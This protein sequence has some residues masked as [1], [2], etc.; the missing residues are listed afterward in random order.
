[1][2]SET[3]AGACPFDHTGVN[4]NGESPAPAFDEVVALM[5]RVQD[6]EPVFFWPAREAWVVAR[7]ESVVKVLMDDRMSAKGKH[8]A[9]DGYY[10]E[11]T[12]AVLSQTTFIPP[13]DVMGTQDAAEHDRLRLPFRAALRATAVKAYEQTISEICSQLIDELEPKRAAEWHAEFSEPLPMRVMLGILGLPVGDASQLAFWSKEMVRLIHVPMGAEEQLR[14][15]GH[16]ADFER[17][18]RDAIAECRAGRGRDGLLRNVVASVDGGTLAL[19]DDE[20]V[21]SFTNEMLLGGFETTATAITSATFNL[22]KDGGAFWRRVVDDPALVPRA[23]EELLRYEP[24]TIGL[25]R[26]ALEDL[27]IEDVVIPAGAKVLWLN[28]AANHDESVFGR[29]DE[30]NVDRGNVRSHLT[31]GKGIHHCIGAPL[32]RFELTLAFT[33]LIE[34]LPSLRLASEQGAMEYLP[35]RSLRTPRRLLVAW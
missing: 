1:M 7:Y 32:A 23:V 13:T 31:F 18:F 22:L 5:H 4:L 8:T 20:L 33:M 28:M 10:T 29:S 21:R 25:P 16:L 15:A 19:T 12:V 17:Y 35:S 11:E 9:A 24:P 26:Y 6:G 14:S 27:T 3:R 30:L 2:T 34:R